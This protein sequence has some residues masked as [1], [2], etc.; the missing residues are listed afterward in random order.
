[1][2]ICCI[3]RHSCVMGI[4]YYWTATLWYLQIRSWGSLVLWNHTTP[5]SM[6]VR[7]IKTTMFKQAKKCNLLNNN[8]VI[9][10]LSDDKLSPGPSH[11]VLRSSSSPPPRSRDLRVTFQQKYS[12]SFP[13]T[14]PFCRTLKQNTSSLLRKTDP[15]TLLT[16]TW[17]TP[18]IRALYL[19]FEPTEGT[20][21]PWDMNFRDVVLSRTPM[22]HHLAEMDTELESHTDRLLRLTRGTKV[23]FSFYSNFIETLINYTIKC[24]IKFIIPVWNVPNVSIWGSNPPWRT[25]VYNI[26]LHPK[27]I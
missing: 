6:R 9:L 25:N 21:K 19:K 14:R 18:E 13:K 10:N 17:S 15:Q 12:N 1:M 24:L 8:I 22:N 2:N 27:I 16:P 5:T 4:I 23:L 3:L 11:S 26:E 7:G 20:N